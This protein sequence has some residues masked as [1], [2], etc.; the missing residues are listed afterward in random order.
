MPKQINMN[1]NDTRNLNS[2]F[3]APKNQND[4]SNDL[5]EEHE[6]LVLFR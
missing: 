3:C 2:N 6:T 5:I 4:F 1:L